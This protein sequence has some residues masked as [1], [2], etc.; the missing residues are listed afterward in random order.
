MTMDLKSRPCSHC[1]GSGV[2]VYD[3]EK[4]RFRAKVLPWVMMLGTIGLTVG[5]CLNVR[6]RWDW[7]PWLIIVVAAGYTI[8][9]F[10]SAHSASTNEKQT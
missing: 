8:G 6:H 7:E 5:Q 4:E 2:E 9:L 1:L 10:W 3:A